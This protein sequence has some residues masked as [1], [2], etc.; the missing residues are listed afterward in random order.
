MAAELVCSPWW[1][2]VPVERPIG[3]DPI[4]PSATLEKVVCSGER[5]TLRRLDLPVDLFTIRVQTNPAKE[6]I[7][8]RGMNLLNG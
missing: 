4:V 7:D 8:A 2:P 6:L 5:Q 3:G 1:Q